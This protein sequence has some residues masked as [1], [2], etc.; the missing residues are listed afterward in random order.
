VSPTRTISPLVTT[1]WLAENIG[2]PGLVVVDIR[3]REEYSTGHIPGAVNVP[4]S[5]WAKSSGSLLMALPT[6]E[7]LFETIG[8]AGIGSG[9]MVVVVNKTDT[10]FTLADAA[11]VAYTLIYGGVKNVAVLN[12]GDNKW[13]KEKRAVSDEAVK[14]QKVAYRGQINDE[15]FVNK[16]YVEKRLGKSVIVDARSPD[17]FFGI[18]QDL[19]TDRPGH[20]PTATCLPAPWLWT[21][22][23]TY[24]SIKEI[25][26][27]VA[28]VVGRDRSKEIIV[29]CGVGGFS[30]ALGFVMR[31][32]LGYTNARVYE[33]AAQEWT[34]D[35]KAPMSR[36]RWD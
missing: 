23:G 27:M 34:A 12:G 4:F 18:T 20:I 7:E 25:R 30:G 31:E 5:S 3:N 29:Y 28:G 36:Y 33:G 32:M 15:M 19:F 21:D 16:A 13:L 9:S 35:P 17:V 14:P 1:K 2:Q 6:D 10:P 22:R 24:R 11:R 8:G 26:A